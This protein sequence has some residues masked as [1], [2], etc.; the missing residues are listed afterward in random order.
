MADEFMPYKPNQVENDRQGVAVDPIAELLHRAIA[1]HQRGD[2][3]AAESDY[4]EALRVMPT[5]ADA[6]HFLGLLL[7]QTGRDR[8]SL[9]LLHRAVELDRRNALYRHNLAGVYKEIGQPVQAERYYREALAVRADYA[10]SWVG[11]AVLATERGK[12]R[13]ALANYERALALDANHYAAGMGRA[14]VLHELGRDQ[15][16]ARAYLGLAGHWDNDVEKLQSLA[17]GLRDAG[18]SMQ[19]LRCLQRVIE[20]D[21]GNV[22]ARN[23]LGITLG[24]LGDLKGAEAAYREVL[25]INPDHVGALYNLSYLKRFNSADPL[26]SSFMTLA[27]QVDS[28]PHKDALVLHF[29]LG[30]VWEDA[31]DYERAFRHFAEGNRIKRAQVDYDE[32]RQVQFVHNY[33]HYFDADFIASAA[34]AGL[35]DATPIFIVGMPRSGT[36][37]V[38][39]VLSSHPQ[40]FGAGELELLWRCVRA[41]LG[42]AEEYDDD[43]PVML[44]ARDTSTIRRIAESYC[45]LLKPLAPTAAHITN[46]LPGNTAMVG[47]M[48]MALPN[49][50]IVHCRR[51]PQDTCV[52]CFSKLFSKG[53]LFSYDLAELGRYYR[54]YEELMQHWRTVL[55]AGSMLELH[56]EDM[57]SDLE[58]QTR[59]LLDYCRLP[60]DDACLKFYEAARPVKTASLT[61]VR[62]PIYAGSVGRWKHYEKYLGPLSEALVEDTSLR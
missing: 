7:H 23:T 54:L 32:A 11:L 53:H 46:K 57:V 29:A 59:R 36:T 39:Q 13:E 20:L 21:P 26:W 40:V 45:T 1:S 15:D 43:L 41:E 19:A 17:Q 27:E 14:R 12:Y 37:L 10:D 42:V 24:N 4:R 22:E 3:A 6:T 35:S 49:A 51:D 8:E 18:E 60:W 2:Y 16:A 38:E 25:R 55:P 47:L 48:H 58:G 44:R 50:R 61:Q 9:S 28:L 5:Q 31:S 52:S 56:Y 34:G 30:K 62:Q 33:M